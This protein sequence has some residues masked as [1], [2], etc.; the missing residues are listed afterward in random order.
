MKLVTA[1]KAT[2]CLWTSLTLGLAMALSLSLQSCSSHSTS[3]PAPQTTVSEYDNLYTEL[4]GDAN[5]EDLEVVVEDSARLAVNLATGAADT[6]SWNSGGYQNRLLIP[7]SAAATPVDL[8]VDCLS[9]RFV[10]GNDSSHTAMM[11]DCSPDGTV[12]QHSLVFDADP[13]QFQNNATSNVVK[14]Y[15]WD[16]SEKRWKLEAVAH[17]TD[18]RIQFE[19]DHFSKYGISD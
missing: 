12:F 9:I 11:L 19:I 3:S 1:R 6:A 16:E 14:L 15:L 13:A 8:E 18:P 2:F 4:F 17:K 7:D 10:K 5:T